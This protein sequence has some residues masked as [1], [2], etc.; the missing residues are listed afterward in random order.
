MP[1]WGSTPLRSLFREIHIGLFVIKGFPKNHETAWP[2]RN[3]GVRSARSDVIFRTPHDQLGQERH[4]PEG[5]IRPELSTSPS[6]A[7]RCGRLRSDHPA[8]QPIAKRLG[9]APQAKIFAS[10]VA[11][12]RIPVGSVGGE[13]AGEEGRGTFV[14]GIPSDRSVCI[15]EVLVEVE[16]VGG[17]TPA[18]KPP[19]QLLCHSGSAHMV[20]C[21]VRRS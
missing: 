14:V 13:A 15:K 1:F 11:R 18:G 6:R 10:S 20:L 8:E 17:F 7:S 3:E 2:V 9:F 5:R 12:D 16:A 19:L 4:R 21:I